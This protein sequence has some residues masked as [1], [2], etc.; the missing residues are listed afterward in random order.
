MA[1]RKR[2]R[3]WFI[4]DRSDGPMLRYKRPDGWKDKRCP[5]ELLTVAEREQWAI[6]V[7]PTLLAVGDPTLEA[8]PP[9]RDT[10]T[11]AQLSEK[12]FEL[13]D[14]SSLAPA[15]KSDQQSSI[16]NHVLT[17]PEMAHTPIAKLGPAAM[18]A[19]IRRL[20]AKGLAPYSVHNHATSLTA[21]LD[22]LISE[23][24]T[25]LVA[26][27][28]RLDG[29][30]KTMPS[31]AP[32][33]GRGTI[34]RLETSD[35]SALLVCPAIPF[36]RRVLYAVALLTGARDGE[37]HGLVWRDVELDAEVPCFH[38][39]R[40]LAIHG[41]D[42]WATPKEP[43]T[44]SSKRTLPLHATA[45]AF[46]TR[47]KGEGYEQWTT[48]K[49]SPGDAVFP[50]AQGNPWRPPAA[51]L[52]RDDL[53]AAGCRTKYVAPDGSVHV[54]TFHA[55][56]RTCATLLSEADVT[57]EDIG[58][59]LGHSGRSTA[60]RFYAGKHAARLKRALDR[61]ALPDVDLGALGLAPGK[62][63][64]PLAAEDAPTAGAWGECPMFYAPSWG[65]FREWAVLAVDLFLSDHVRSSGAARHRGFEPLTYGSGGRRSIQ[66]S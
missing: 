13:R 25:S 47:W 8:L 59:V 3:G 36:H 43:K 15:T 11:L 65:D 2:G 24:L 50:S 55:L 39:R 52:L 58:A 16:R 10:A 34:V 53:E 29:V 14:A 45:L 46:L 60:E 56:R 57:A 38:V 37:L 66:L 31:A 20:A 42:G 12:W 32:L 33:A 61:I 54:L 22:D 7:L 35:A 51:R 48:R 21:M 23:E 62:P 30:R 44:E 40:S 49:P 19:W 64:F 41:S 5:A 27:P 17:D 6:G 4:I 63:G 18:R 28:M 9:T 26:N 1:R